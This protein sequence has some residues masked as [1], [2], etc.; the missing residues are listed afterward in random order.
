[1]KRVYLESPYKG[2][3]WEN[4]EENLRFA[5][6][7]MRDCLVNHNEAPYASHLLY[8]QPEVLDDKIES[9][10]ELGGFKAGPAFKQV[11]DSSVFYINRGISQGM[12]RGS[13]LSITMRQEFE[14]RL[15]PG[16][17]NSFPRPIICTIT[18]ASGAG[19][20]SV[21]KKLLLKRPSLQLVKSFT[22]RMPRESDLFGEYQCNIPREDLEADEKSFL[23]LVEAHG[24]LYGTR[25]DSVSEM[26]EGPIF[27]SPMP[28]F[29]VLVPSAVMLLRQYVSTLVNNPEDQVVSFYI[30]SP[31]EKELRRRLT[32]RGDDKIS[33]RKRIKD[34]RKWD[35]DALSSNLPYIFLPNRESDQEPSEWL[36]KQISLFF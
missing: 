13:L 15:L 14:Y 27:A 6:L 1:M 8:T 23:W 21:V 17:P 9:E 5:R 19:K 22:T 11:C 32:V 20:S 24:N 18:G 25:R 36:A 30:L 2:K 12:H 26:F 10:R 16:Y 7:C 28:K 3:N 29:M 35:E 4:T 34:C 31:S 33:I